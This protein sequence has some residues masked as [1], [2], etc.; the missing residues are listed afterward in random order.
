MKP[1]KSL[2]CRGQMGGPV[3]TISSQ[4]VGAISILHKAIMWEPVRHIRLTWISAKKKTTLE[5]CARIE[6]LAGLPFICRQ[7]AIEAHLFPTL[8]HIR[9][10]ILEH[11]FYH[12][13]SLLTS[14]IFH[15]LSRMTL[16]V[17]SKR[18]VRVRT[19][20]MPVHPH[21]L[22]TSSHHVHTFRQFLRKET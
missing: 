3:P 18:A 5:I 8:T 20:R 14:V 12:I 6:M 10:P 9:L 19:L 1:E 4:V 17:V 13:F 7:A 15:F 22:R 21:F 16:V 11:T 2:P